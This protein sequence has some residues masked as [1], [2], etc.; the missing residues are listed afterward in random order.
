[1]TV[2]HALVLCLLAVGFI[3]STALSHQHD[4]LD[5]GI[6][7]YTPRAG[8]NGRFA[9]AG[10]TTLQPLLT[11]LRDQ[12][13]RHHPGVMLDVQP[14]GGI[15]L[16]DLL[17][18][19]MA[20]NSMGD[21][22]GAAPVLM[23]ASLGPIPWSDLDTFYA[24]RGYPPTTVTIAFKAIGVY[25]HQDNPVQGVTVDQLEAV[26]AEIRKRG[27]AARIDQWGALG[28]GDGWSTK[29]V[30]LYAPES[31]TVAQGFFSELVLG[32]SAMIPTVKEEQSPQSLLADLASD[33]A[34]LAFD[35]IGLEVAG[36][37]A[38]P[39]ADKAGQPYV[40]PTIDLACQGS[41]PLSRFVYLYVDKPP[42]ESL[43]PAVKE[44]LMFT[45]SREGQA[46]ALAAGFY[47]LREEHVAGNLSQIDV[48][49]ER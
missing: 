36:V 2:L 7:G 6:A 12:F 11:S 31:R 32:G 38:L 49:G 18:S 40:A 17:S 24:R 41:Y 48:P 43:P 16:R 39:I 19:S 13:H 8:L 4:S 23:I 26:Y 35:G 47:T 10:S 30:R 34:G 46:A 44:F 15:T 22:R 28:G 37:R 9:V 29:P 5:P 25:V 21:S 42:G 33:T 3:E 14:A 27:L 45:N 1:M 20:V